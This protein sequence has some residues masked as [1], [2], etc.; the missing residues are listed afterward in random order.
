MIVRT[1][2]DVRTCALADVDDMLA[3]LRELGAA[4]IDFKRNVAVVDYTIGPDGSAEDMWD[5]RGVLQE[6]EC[7]LSNYVDC[8]CVPKPR[9]L[10]DGE[11]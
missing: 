5:L 6:L 7:E 1:E 3:K 10:E 9:Q 8:P 4:T 2:I 11:A